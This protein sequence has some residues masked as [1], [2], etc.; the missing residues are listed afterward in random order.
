[1]NTS[2]FSMS[3]SQF[4]VKVLATIRRFFLAAHIRS[5]SALSDTIQR[6]QSSHYFVIRF[7]QQKSM[8]CTKRWNSR[9]S[10]KGYSSFKTPEG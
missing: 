10:S 8:K 9:K 3:P 6:C 7:P 5:W 4:R 2:F 1:M